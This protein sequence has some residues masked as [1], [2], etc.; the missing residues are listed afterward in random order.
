[1]HVSSEHQRTTWQQML[2]ENREHNQYEETCSHRT[3][4]ENI[5]YGRETTKGISGL[6]VHGGNVVICQ[7]G[8]VYAQYG[9]SDRD[10]QAQPA[11]IGAGWHHVRDSLLSEPDSDGSDRR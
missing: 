8:P 6:P 3:V 2:Y 5:I 9:L 10:R 1:M 7:R 4:K 11:A